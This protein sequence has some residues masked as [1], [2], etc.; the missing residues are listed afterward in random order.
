[1]KRK[2]NI[3]FLLLFVFAKQLVAQQF[4]PQIVS[5]SVDTTLPNNKGRVV[6]N[7]LP[8]K[9]AAV[10]YFKLYHY[11]GE[12][13]HDLGYKIDAK[14]H[15]FIYT[16]AQ[17]DKNKEGFTM[18]SVSKDSNFDDGIPVS[19]HFTMFLSADKYDICEKT[20]ILT[21]SAYVGW[22]SELKEYKVYYK[23]DNEPY[24]LKTTIDAQKTNCVFDKIKAGSNYKF[25]IIAENSS[26]TQS[27]SNIIQYTIPPKETMNTIMFYT[28]SVIYD[29][30]KVDISFNTDVDAK[31]EGYSILR[32]I[33]PKS[34]SQIKFINKTEQQRYRFSDIIAPNNQQTQYKI[35]AIDL[36]KDTIAQTDTVNL[37][38]LK[39]KNKKNVVTLNWGKTFEH[40]NEQYDVFL[41]VNNSEFK[42]IEQG[43]EENE[44]KYNL[45]HLSNNV[46]EHFCFKIGGHTTKGY[47]SQY[48]T[49][50]FSI[51]PEI[52]MPNAFT[53]NDDGLNDYI[54]PLIK[55]AHIIEYKFIV[56]NQAG[57]IVFKTDNY[58]E[59][60]DGK[61][62]NSSVKEGAYLYFF[63]FTT[64]SKNKYKKSGV[65]NVIYP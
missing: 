57:G 27:I 20:L 14:K 54:K 37:P 19:P 11:A 3:I 21:W 33:K 15:T 22:G 59:K 30:R 8:T 41:S 46:G 43:I 51:I 7:Y 56:Y 60:W 16:E 63:E 26:G 29:G 49:V 61:A 4:D 23:A 17:A 6:I 55:Y 58:E 28:D 35:L 64:Y 34:F 48:N 65:I 13:L 31:I 25:Y 38:I 32:S 9:H 24:K 45:I 62:Y 40:F 36:C 12:N 47:I 44:K 1:M 53:P 10:D 39:G 50:C 2:Q 18:S 5:V 42:L 52:K